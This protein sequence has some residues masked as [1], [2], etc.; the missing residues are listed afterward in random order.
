MEARL[1]P[2]N[3]VLDLALADGLN[4]AP[5]AIAGWRVVCLETPVK[6]ALGTVVCDVVLF[7]ASTGHLLVAEA[8]SG[9]NIEEAQARKL[10]VIDPVTLV[11]AGGITIPQAVQL[12]REAMFVCLAEHVDRITLGVAAAELAIP[13]LAVDTEGARLANPAL[14]SYELAAAFGEVTL[15][16]HPVARIIPFD[17][18]S[19]SRVFD[20]PVRAELVAQL[21]RRRPSVTMRALTEQVVTHF[22]LY[23]KRAQ[24]QLVAKVTEAARKAADRAPGRLRFERATGTTEPRIVILSSPEEFDTRGRTQGYQALFRAR[25]RRRPTPQ[26]PGQMDLF[27]E[28]DEAERVTEGDASQ[29]ETDDRDDVMGGEKE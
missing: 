5:L 20:S 11:S 25:N 6:T 28:L 1:V 9:A 15:W 26:I 21:D 16:T 29:N 7:N 24:G 2:V 14:A 3:A 12:R 27:S 8:K 13:V 19:P 10:A 17:H 18:E 4:P 23:G 22:A